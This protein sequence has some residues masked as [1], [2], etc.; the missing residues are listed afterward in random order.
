MFDGRLKLYQPSRGYRFTTDSLLLTAFARERCR[1]A[2]ADLGTGCGILPVLLARQDAVSRILG[3]ELQQDLADL[4]SR[5]IELNRC[6]EKVT[7]PRSQSMAPA[8]PMLML[9]SWDRSILS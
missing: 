6:G 3:I 1:G 9:P 4:A 5:N 7:S 2:L 8:V